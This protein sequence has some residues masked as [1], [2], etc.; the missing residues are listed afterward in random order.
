MDFVER[1]KQFMEQ[2]GISSSQFADAAGIPRPTLSQILSGRNKKISNEV[3][4]KLHTAFPQL[5]VLWLLFGDGSMMNGDSMQF[6]KPQNPL[7][8]FDSP[9]QETEDKPVDTQS[10]SQPNIQ[11]NSRET[12]APYGRAAS[13]PQEPKKVS[14]ID[15]E[16]STQEVGQIK[17][18]S[19]ASDKSINYVLVFYTDGSFEVFRPSP[20]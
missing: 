2:L 15:S 17:S 18:I 9:I 13:F 4:S 19:A 11:H 8:L 20:K 1:L 12:F 5:N 14:H 3:I 7:N 16:S 6:S 10:I